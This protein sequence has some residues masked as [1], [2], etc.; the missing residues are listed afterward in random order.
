MNPLISVIVPVY[1]VEAYLDRCVESI[2]NQ[3]YKNLEIILVDD[4]STDNSGNKCDEWAS[5]DNRIVVIHKE[6]GGQAAARNEG[7]K[8]AKGSL[9]GF[10]D[11]DDYI[12][13]TMY[14]S[15]QQIMAINEADIAECD[16]FKFYDQNLVITPSKSDSFI[17][18][19]REEAIKDFLLEAHLKC[20]VPNMLIKADIAKQVLFDE[21]KTHEDILWPYRAY[22]LSDKV[23]YIDTKLYYYFQRP[24][25]TMNKTYSTKRFDGL[26]ALEERAKLV[27][28]DFPS[29]YQIANRSYLGSCMYQYQYLCRQ[30]KSKEFEGYKKILYS[31]FCNGDQV[32]LFDGL[33]IKYRFWYSLFKIVPGFTAGIRNLLK[34][35]V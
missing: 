12:D 35:G 17:V 3:T 23:I 6:N 27:K 15:M 33:T 20:T 11:S 7:L 18:M 32:A 9:I 16:M 30:P 19:N 1:N 2:V 4:G 21:G 34:I 28:K 24:G 8:I 29:L 25:S 22:V 5:N 14:K 31:R 13:L 26:D 10:V